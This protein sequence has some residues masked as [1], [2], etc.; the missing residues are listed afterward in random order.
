[1]NMVPDA[2]AVLVWAPLLLATVGLCGT[3]LVLILRQGRTPAVK[4]PR[5]AAPKRPRI[6]HAHLPAFA[7]T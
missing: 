5:A 3:L 6:R 1:M 4:V 7:R 2:F